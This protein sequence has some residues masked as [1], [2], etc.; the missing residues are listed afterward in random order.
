MIFLKVD[1]KYSEKVLSILVKELFRENWVVL[2]QTSE[3]W[4]HVA[5]QKWVYSIMIQIKTS[6]RLLLIPWKLVLWIMQKTIGDLIGLRL[7]CRLSGAHFLIH[8]CIW[9]LKT[10]IGSFHFFVIEWSKNLLC[11]PFH[12][13]LS[14]LLNF[15]LALWA[16]ILLQLMAIK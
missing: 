2:V 14:F 16:Q 6:T 5:R 15:M 7:I 11:D 9:F 3:T 12:F 8:F 10:G 1:A 4:G 13:L